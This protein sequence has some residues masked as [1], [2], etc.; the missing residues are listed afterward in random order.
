[1]TDAVTDR[2]GELP[3][4]PRDERAGIQD[5]IPG[6][7][8]EKIERVLPVAVEVFDLRELSRLRLAPMEDRNLVA[9]TRRFLDERTSE[10]P[11]AADRQ[12]LHPR[13]PTACYA[14]RTRS[15]QP[16]SYPILRCA[17]HRTTKES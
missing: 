8:G 6:P 16:C 9:A 3:D 10:E 12:D 15:T 14:G 1:M 7:P 4:L 13:D 17:G 5:G 2:L 11:C